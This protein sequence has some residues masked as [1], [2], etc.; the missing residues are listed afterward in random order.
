MRVSPFHFIFC[1]NVVWHF[2]ANFTFR[3]F[4][5]K[6]EEK[7]GFFNYLVFLGGYLKIFGEGEDVQENFG[8]ML[9]F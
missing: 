6:L 9:L 4:F 8:R 2:F 1:E 7:L 5:L 3:I